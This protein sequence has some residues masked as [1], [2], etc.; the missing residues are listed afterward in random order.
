MGYSLEKYIKGEKWKDIPGYEGIYQAS[1]FGRIRTVEGKKTYSVYH[2]ERTWTSRILKPKNGAEPMGY[3]VSLW[4]DKKPKDYLVARLIGFTFLGIPEH[5]MTINHKDGNRFN[6]DLSNLEWLTLGDNIRHGFDNG[7][8]PQKKVI[9]H[10]DGTSREYR[11]M[12]EA[13]KGLGRC[14]SYISLCVK[15]GRDAKDINNKIYKIKIV[16]K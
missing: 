9:L 6:N 15:H 12:V 16:N 2:G 7:L 13:S 1:T 10:T 8:Y 4:K 3:R 5:G 14:Q 11:S